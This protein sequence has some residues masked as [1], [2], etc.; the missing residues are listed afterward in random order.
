MPKKKNSNS[1]LAIILLIFLLLILI[2]V[3]VGVY[4]KFRCVK[5][6]NPYKLSSDGTS[7]VA[8][9]DGDDCRSCMTLS[10]CK[11]KLSNPDSGP[12]QP[13]SCTKPSNPYR[14]STDKKSCVVCTNADPCTDCFTLETCKS[15]LPSKYKCDTSS[16]SSSSTCVKCSDPT[17]PTCTFTEPTCGNSC[18]IKYKYN[19]DNTNCV[20]CTDNNDS[21]CKYT[22]LNTCLDELSVDNDPTQGS[23]TKCNGNGQYN[24]LTKSCECTKDLFDKDLDV[25]SFG[26]TLPKTSDEW[27]QYALASEHCVIMD[28]DNTSGDATE[29]GDIKSIDIPY[30]FVMV[31]MTCKLDSANQYIEYIQEIY[32]MDIKNLLLGK[33]NGSCKTIQL[34]W[35]NSKSSTPSITLLD[36]N[37][38]S[39]A[40]SQVCISWKPGSAISNFSF[41]YRDL[42]SAGCTSFQ[43][44]G[45]KIDN[46]QQQW[47]PPSSG[48]G[49]V[50]PPVGIF[51]SGFSCRVN[52]TGIRQVLDMRFIDYKKYIAKFSLANTSIIGSNLFADDKVSVFI[53]GEN[54][55][56]K[57]YDRA[58]LGWNEPRNF[59]VTLL[60]NDT[61]IR[62]LVENLYG[63][64]T[65]L[66][67]API[68]G[69][70]FYG[71]GKRTAIGPPSLI[72]PINLELFSASTPDAKSVTVANADSNVWVPAVG[73]SI[74]FMTAPQVDA[75]NL[76][77][78]LSKL[79]WQPF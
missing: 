73:N 22:D 12:S 70:T 51:L 29:N 17:D 21:N 60:P 54:G 59:S 75:Y 1:G 37:Y 13:P 58:E 18:L 16:T 74:W 45:A 66:G 38:G 42:V 23:V 20:V 5:P 76:D 49:D 78:D 11:A 9:T 34:N 64:P 32:T 33:T 14:I 30:G 4:L 3:G 52:E 72:A 10:D 53:T 26:T 56:R 65:G 7:C 61:K 40:I 55:T 50:N 27:K 41:V 47:Y 28:V 36:K 19:A 68:K 35:G 8:C 57:V 62:F 79:M 44:L 48:T 63:G 6:Q 15:K 77:I 24:K 39:S 2:G 46:P 31:G 71:L 67:F 43:T 69:T 25:S